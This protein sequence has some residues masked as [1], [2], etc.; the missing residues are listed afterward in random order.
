MQSSLLETLKQEGDSD[1]EKHE[2]HDP[3]SKHLRPSETDC[4]SELER[5]QLQN[6]ASGDQ[7]RAP[8]KAKRGPYQK[9]IKKNRHLSEDM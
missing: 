8:R 9:H 6:Q 5:L 7:R 4:G 2:R 1:K 3:R